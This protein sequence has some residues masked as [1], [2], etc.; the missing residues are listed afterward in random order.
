MIAETAQGATKLLEAL[1]KLGDWAGGAA[2]GGGPSGPPAQEV[3]RAFE[4]AL[5][6]ASVQTGATEQGALASAPPDSLERAVL[7]GPAEQVPSVQ[8]VEALPESGA[9]PAAQGMEVVA[10]DGPTGPV[11]S[12]IVSEPA[13]LEQTGGRPMAQE[14]PAQELFRRLENTARPG[15]VLTPQ[16][17]FR[18]QYLVGILKVQVQAGVS[19][20][21]QSTQGMESLLRQSG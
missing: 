17:L 5:D 7:P 19:S 4:E 13:S 11:S 10:V 1:E 18:I 3:V 6:A 16:E 12:A 2:T 21:Q 8:S 9:Q 14:D 20:S 15:S